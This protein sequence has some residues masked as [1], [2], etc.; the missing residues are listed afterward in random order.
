MAF[1]RGGVFASMAL[2]LGIVAGCANFP[3]ESPDPRV[4]FPNRAIPSGR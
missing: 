3:T 1:R 2:A 4:L